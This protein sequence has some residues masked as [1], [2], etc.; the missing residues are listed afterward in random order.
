MFG[1]W[2]PDMARA[3]GPVV[4]QEIPRLTSP[5]LARWGLSLNVAHARPMHSPTA[6]A[7]DGWAVLLSGRWAAEYFDP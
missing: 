2:E 6:Q 4:R 1:S 7:L 5:T 3:P